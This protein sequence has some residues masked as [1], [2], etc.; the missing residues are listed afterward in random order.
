[1]NKQEFADTLQH[2]IERPFSALQWRLLLLMK[3]DYKHLFHKVRINLIHPSYS[4]VRDEGGKDK[5]PMN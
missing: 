3:N 4:W 1:M 5:L 2:T